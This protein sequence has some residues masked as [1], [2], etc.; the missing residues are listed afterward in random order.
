MDIRTKDWLYGV[1]TSQPT[2][3]TNDTQGVPWTEAERLRTIYDMMT[4][5]CADGGADITPG[6]GYWKNV[7]S[8]F[9]LHDHDM[10]REWIKSW[11]R[12]TL[13]D[14]NDLE[15]IRVKL[16]EKV[17]FYFTF[18]QTYF[19]FLMVPA[20][21]G[22]FCWVFL[23]HFSIFY[24]VWNSL[25][26]LVF[27]E[28]WKRQELDLRLRWQVKGVSE[29]KARRK[30]YKHEKEII[31]PITGETVYVFP[32]SKRLVRQ[33]LVIPFTMAVVVA[34]GTLIA[35]CFAIEVFINEIYSGPFQTYLV[36][37]FLPLT[38]FLYPMAN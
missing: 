3:D 6:Y 31:D 22:L 26:C 15:Q 7:K 19:R 14:N 29:I 25:F 17:A 13:L 38:R 24:A 35:T 16:G 32:A 4:L 12:K 5:P 1:R 21:L 9:P 30:E 11:S 18:L 20:G 27:V 2:K 34:L 28:F 33:L 8:I 10:N 37:Q 36:C 23:G